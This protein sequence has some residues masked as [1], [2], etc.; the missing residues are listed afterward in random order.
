MSRGAELYARRPPAQAVYN[1]WL[2]DWLHQPVGVHQFV[3]DFLQDLF[4]I[5][6]VSH[7]PADE[8][9]RARSRRTV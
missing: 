1:W 3:E 2:L 8:V 7:A 9:E 6:V 5:T 4:R